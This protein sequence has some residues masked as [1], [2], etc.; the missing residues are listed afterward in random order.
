MIYPITRI[1][2]YEKNKYFWPPYR[3]DECFFSRTVKSLKLNL[4]CQKFYTF[5]IEFAVLQTV[6]R[7]DVI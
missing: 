5:Q 4:I 3:R 7:V 2:Y 6:K 1:E